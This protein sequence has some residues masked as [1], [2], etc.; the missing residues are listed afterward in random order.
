MEGVRN[1]IAEEWG[2]TLGFEVGGVEDECRRI[3]HSNEERIAGHR[4]KNCSRIYLSRPLIL[5]FSP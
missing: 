4:Q 5:T 3:L 2:G 1:P